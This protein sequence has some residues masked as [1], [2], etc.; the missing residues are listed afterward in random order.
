M[1]FTSGETKP[2]LFY[3]V[4]AVGDVSAIGEAEGQNWVQAEGTTVVV[5]RPT[6]SGNAAFFQAV[7]TPKDPTSNK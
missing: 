1:V 6:V 5:E 2:G 3:G 7:C 4:K